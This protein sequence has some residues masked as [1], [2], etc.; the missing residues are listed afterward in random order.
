MI[1]KLPFCATGTGVTVTVYVLL[2]HDKVVS[3][4]Y[5]A[6]KVG[7][8]GDANDFELEMHDG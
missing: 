5:E 3:T 4:V 1:T 2:P 7:I 8:V 6:V